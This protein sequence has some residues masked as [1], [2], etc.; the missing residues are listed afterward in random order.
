MTINNLKILVVTR[1]F[2]PLW[3]GMERLNQHLVD[4]LS[5]RF[6]VCLIAPQGAEQYAPANVRVKT[7]PLSPLSNFLVQSAFL[8]IAEARRWKPD[9]VVAGS[10]LT[11]P[12]AL[13]GGKVCGA[14]S[15][16]YAHGLDMTVNHFI[17]RS[18]WYPSIRKLDYLIANSRATVDLAC[19]SV[20]VLADRV[21]L[22]HP[23]VEMPN[24]SSLL[25]QKEREDAK[26]NFCKTFSVNEGPM[27]LSVGRLTERKGLRQF[28][29]YV[30]PK[31]VTAQPKVKLVIVGDEP[32]DSLH[33]SVQTRENIQSAADAVGIG[34]RVYFMGKLFGEELRAAYQSADVHVFPVQ[35]IPN[36]PE[37]F[38]MVAIEAAAYGLPT[39]AYATGGVVDAVSHGI[40]GRLVRS[41]DVEGFAAQV[42]DLLNSP[43]NRQDMYNYAQQFSW[44]EFGRKLETVVRGAL[45][46]CR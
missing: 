39:V 24:I 40:S 29:K 1:N 6:E 3:G 26:A 14:R 19:Q 18:L 44:S 42:L 31:I 25:S 8:V 30:M 16:A 27:L 35:E 22:I 37:G 15:I 41:G 43:A 21:K 34:D 20:G 38:G 45:S 33:A 13:I 9:L 4:E 46:V 5:K 28:V 17:Y 11:A 12:H 7:V 23:G 10:G 32:T 36:D 2:P